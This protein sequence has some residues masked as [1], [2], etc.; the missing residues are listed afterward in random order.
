MFIV[1]LAN[2]LSSMALDTTVNLE[3][4]VITPKENVSKAINSTRSI[5]I[6]TDKDIESSPVHSVEELLG[7][8]QSVDVKRRG[9]YGVQS[10]MS[11]RGVTFEEVL[12][13]INGIRMNDPQTGHHNMDLPITLEDIERIEITRGASSAFYGANAFGGVINIITKKPEGKKTKISA[14]LGEHSL[15]RQSISTSYPLGISNN[16]LTFERK[17]SS[18]YHPETEFDIKTFYLNSLL[19]FDKTNLGYLLG[20]TK[21]DFGADSFYSSA[22]PREEEHTDTRFL[23]VNSKINYPN[24][25]IKPHFYYRRHHDKY[26]LD[27]TRP[28]FYLNFHTVYSYGGGFEVD[29][30]L[31]YASIVL[32][33]DFGQEKI[34]STQLGG[35]TRQKKSMFMQLSP[36]IDNGFIVALGVRADRYSNWGWQTNPGI[37]IGYIINPRIKLKASANRAFRVPSFTEL[38]YN[39]PSNKGS[40]DLVP[41]KGWTYEV[42]SDFSLE[43]FS[44]QLNLFRREADDLIDW[45]KEVSSDPWQTQNIGKMD[46]DGVEVELKFIPEKKDS[47]CGISLSEFLLG[48]TYIHSSKNIGNL[49]SKYALE[50]LEHQASSG[51]KLDLPKKINLTSKLSYKERLNKRHYFM[52]DTRISKK[53]EME[54]FNIEYFINATNLLNTSYT[55]VTGVL[56]PGRWIEIGTTIEF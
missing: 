16:R 37:N 48:Y 23:N 12:I 46:T 28:F 39:S 8:I 15:S 33:T 56:M 52:L 7:H 18:G 26:I 4:I 31:P 40:T 20:Y 17:E 50:Y 49:S 22:Y 13:L 14:L 47:S 55:E 10:D 54:K 32:G 6:I 43:R 11:I 51:I 36:K 44:G 53:K 34:T 21:K 5:H 9:I 42:G 1:L 3:P 27:R 41:E 45:V 24:I 25:I 38:Y 19:E 30:D 2:A 35:H 29:F